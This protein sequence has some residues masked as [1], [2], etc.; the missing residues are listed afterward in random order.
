MKDTRVAK[1]YAAALFEVAKRD[2]IL[3]AVGE[4]LLLVERLVAE[5]STLRTVFVQPLVTEER[6]AKM[7]TDVF[8]DRITATS[9]SF[10][11][12]L[13]SKRRGDLIDHVIAAFRQLLAQHL[14]IVD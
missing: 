4:D 14:N 12:L 13:I 9:L 1:R 7:V 5:L 10:L 8:G 11:K 2:S 3:D 6:K